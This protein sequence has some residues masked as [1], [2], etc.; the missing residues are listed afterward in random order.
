[1]GGV[2]TLEPVS[3]AGRGGSRP[4]PELGMEVG[5]R[6][7]AELYDARCPRLPTLA[8]KPR[9]SPPE[10]EIL[11]RVASDPHIRHQVPEGVNPDRLRP[12]VTVGADGTVAEAPRE[13]GAWVSEPCVLILTATPQAPLTPS[14]AVVYRFQ[15]VQTRRGP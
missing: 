9:R 8:L 14:P 12:A 5:G 3:P 7:V 10:E 4:P 2:R 13:P 15:T 11:L 6:E 1:V